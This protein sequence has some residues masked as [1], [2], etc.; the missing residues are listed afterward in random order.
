[1]GE[2]SQRVRVEL[3]LVDDPYV[4]TC[5]CWSRPQGSPN[6]I[7]LEGM[8][9]ERFIIKKIDFIQIEI[10]A[11]VQAHELDESARRTLRLTINN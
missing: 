7:I 5:L 10:W 11:I 8:I 4:C 3:A 6:T 1:M 2:C 9:L